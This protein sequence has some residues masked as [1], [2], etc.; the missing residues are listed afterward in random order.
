[1]T[2]VQSNST[3]ARVVGDRISLGPSLR[4]LGQLEFEASCA[5]LMQLV[6]QDYAPTLVVGIRTGGLVVAE[7][8][9]RAASTAMPVLP[10]TCRRATTGAKSRIPLFR[11][12]LATLPQ[13]LVDLLRRVEHRLFI[14]SRA[15]S[16]RQQLIDLSEVDAIADW[17]ARSDVPSRILLA[18]DAVDSGVT[19]GTVLRHL[20]AAC[21]AGTEIRTAVITQTLAQPVT[22]PDY[23]LFHGTL[24]RF[25]WSF[26]ARH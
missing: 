14:A 21:P 10:V 5:E 8:M 3:F 24:C 22:S 18:D 13:P 26:D 23:S 2:A 20:R 16:T 11:A 15:H 1:V 25:P 12:A 19:L 17:T 7:C 6:E 4:T 9:I